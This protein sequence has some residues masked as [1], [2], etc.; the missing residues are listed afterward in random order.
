MPTAEPLRMEPVG[1]HGVPF[2]AATWCEPPPREVAVPERAKDGTAPFDSQASFVHRDGH[3]PLHSMSA[4]MPRNAV[5][6]KIEC[7]PSPKLGLECPARGH[8]IE[9]VERLRE[10]GHNATASAELARRGLPMTFIGDHPQQVPG[11]TG[12]LRWPSNPERRAE[13]RSSSRRIAGECQ[14]PRPQVQ[15]GEARA[16]GVRHHEA[17]HARQRRCRAARCRRGK[18]SSLHSASAPS[19]TTRLRVRSVAA[20]RA[21]IGRVAIVIDNQHAAPDHGIAAVRPSPAATRRDLHARQIDTELAALAE[22]S[23]F[24]STRRRASRP[25]AD[26][27]QADAEPSMT[28]SSERS[29]CRNWSK[30]CGNIC[31]SIPIPSSR[32]LS[33]TSIR[34]LPAISIRS[35]ALPANT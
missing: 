12:L 24:A 17:V 32:T 28:R 18:S 26:K 21:R 31:G 27:S 2:A 34:P 4:S 10:R 7:E 3:L 13:M 8:E 15:C 1:D 14:Q 29:P 35:R 22:P 20:V 9:F 30:T 16:D 33:T 5:K 6:P 19:V 23:L 25:G 11:S